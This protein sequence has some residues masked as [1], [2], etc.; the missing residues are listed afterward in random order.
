[1]G[2]IDAKFDAAAAR[3]EAGGRDAAKER[4]DLKSNITGLTVQMGEVAK[5]IAEIR[6]MHS[7]GSPYTGGP[8]KPVNE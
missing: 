2:G 7:R 6:A 1:L 3:E 4:S 8:I 5:G